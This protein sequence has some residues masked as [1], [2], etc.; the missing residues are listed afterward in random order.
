MG[1]PLKGLCC[2][3][4]LPVTATPIGRLAYQTSTE[5]MRKKLRIKWGF[6]QNAPQHQMTLTPDQP[7]AFCLDSS[8]WSCN[9]NWCLP[10]QH[11]PC[12]LAMPLATTIHLRV[13]LLLF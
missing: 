11:P 12:L 5:R 3:G 8:N 2:R 6:Q 9:R 7:T 13:V 1:V 4:R 10:P